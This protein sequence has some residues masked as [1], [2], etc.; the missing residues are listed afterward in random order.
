MLSYAYGSVLLERSKHIAILILNRPEKLNALNA[1][2]VADIHSALDEISTDDNIRSLIITGN[3]RAFSSGVDVNSQLA[4]IENRVD[5]SN[6]LGPDVTEISPHI[7]LM[8]QPVIAAINGLS[9][10]A[11]LSIALASD[12][13]IASTEALFSCM[14]VKRSLVP[15]A[16]CSYTLPKIVGMGI[17]MEMALSGNIYDSQWALEKRL[18]NKV[19]DHESLLDS[20]IALAND[21]NSNPPIT[22]RSTKQ[23]MY[24]HQP[25]LY[26]ILPS[27]HSANDPTKGTLD[28][29]EAARSFLEKRT[30]IYNDK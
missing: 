14:F 9:V 28:R 27:E 30:P 13:R 4:S 7:R 23:I 26:E 15:D 10:G 17:A 3:G 6:P 5:P 24:D 25:T 19:V 16:G 20:A 21:I 29:L 2:L 12:I 8:P 11:G 18:V 1:F 22:I